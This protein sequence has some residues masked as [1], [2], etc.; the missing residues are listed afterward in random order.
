M[1]VKLAFDL[2][3]V[4]GKNLLWRTHDVDQG[5][6]A[7]D[8]ETAI[9]GAEGF[10]RLLVKLKKLFKGK[11]VVAWEGRGTNWRNVIEPTYKANR[12]N[13]KPEQI[14]EHLQVMKQIPILQELLSYLGVRQFQGIDCEGDDVMA[15]LA[16]NAST[17]SIRNPHVGATSNLT[18]A[19][20]S[21]DRDLLQLVNDSM[22]VHQIMPESLKR[23]AE[24]F[25]DDDSAERTP[26]GRF[27]RECDVSEIFGIP[28]SLIPDYKGLAG[29]PGDNISG[30]R[31]IGAQ[32]AK[33]LIDRAGNLDAIIEGCNG[34]MFDDLGNLRDKIRAS[35]EVARKC[36][37]LAS[38]K[39]DAQIEEIAGRRNEDNAHAML[40]RFGMAK[41]VDA[42]T[43]PQLME[44]A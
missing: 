12:A 5:R 34:N 8:A 19:I 10:L 24:F 40:L 20:Y 25:I 44:I 15:T 16:H 27:M 22:V 31:G 38:V 37:Q 35:A 6:L 36:K 41:F 42:K 3:I 7:R 2:I 17:A 29:D 26:V 9:G 14:A 33:I 13:R 30:V 11:I 23:N 18:V 32:K 28:A 43:F 1:N 21:R 39:R 4:D